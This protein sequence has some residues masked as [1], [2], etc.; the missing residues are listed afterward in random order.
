MTD[1]KTLSVSDTAK[2]LGISK[3][4]AYALFRQQDFPSFRI[5]NRLLVAE[6]ALDK[7]LAAQSGGDAQ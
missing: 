3:P 4:T 2:L 1:K 5:G 6:A 7:W